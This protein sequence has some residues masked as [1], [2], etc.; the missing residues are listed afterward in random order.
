MSVLRRS[1]KSFLGIDIGTSAVKIVE[2]A[3]EANQATLLNYG[4]LKTYGYLRRLREPLQSSVMTTL[5]SDVAAMIRQILDNSHAQTRRASMSIPLFSSFFTM[6]EFPPMSQAELQEAILFQA[7]QIV[8]VPIAEVILDWEVIGRIGHADPNGSR[9]KM[10]ILLVAVPREIVDRYV[11]I[12]KLA[13]IELDA[14]EVEAFSL[15]RGALRNDMRTLLLADIGARSTNLVLIDE[16]TIRATHSLDTSGSEL[17][18]AVA[19][20]MSIEVGRA[21]AAKIEQGIEGAGSEM[22]R[23]LGSVIEVIVHEMEKMISTYQRSYGSP[24]QGVLLAGGSAPLIGL[25]AYVQEKLHIPV[26]RVAPFQNV[27]APQELMPVLQ[28]I[29]PS[30][31]V[32]VGLALRGIVAPVAR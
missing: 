14:L 13:A 3:G 1:Q 18:T 11:R 16:G 25:D 5:D 6:L 2:L 27:R 8:P 15:V 7:R 19:R 23:L 12:A 24:V 21:E 28:E 17:T 9:E 30:F 4:E 22:R 32:A 10:L 20:A 29:G 31:T 26:S